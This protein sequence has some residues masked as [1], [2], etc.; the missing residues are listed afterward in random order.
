MDRLLAQIDNY[1]ER[2][3][4]SYWAEPI[5]AVTNLAFLIAAFWMWRRVND[6]LG[7]ALCLTLAAIGSGSYLFHT[8]AT[9]W[10]VILDVLP[11][12]IFILIYI[13]AAH[14][15]FWGLPFWPAIGATLLYFPYSY[16]VSSVASS[17]PF[18]S[19]SAQYWP[20]PLL[21][22][23]YGLALRNRQ[24]AT[25]T[26]LLIGAGLLCVSLIARSLDEIVCAQIPMGTHFL[27]H[28]FNG[29]MLGWMIEVYRRH[30]L[31][32]RAVRG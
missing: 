31:A 12:L 26:G 5:N 4:P 11:I 9:V 10:S 32:V 15:S 1:C 20:L 21:I 2:T 23:A 3:D 28:I 27:W 18:F 16:G 25:G 6:G 22:A 8:H 29:I 24:R 14:R 7:R 13:Y 30:M 19:I 17:V